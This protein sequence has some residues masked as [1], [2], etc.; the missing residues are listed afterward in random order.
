MPLIV[1]LMP[2]Y[3][4]PHEADIHVNGQ[5]VLITFIISVASGILFGIAPA[6]QL[7]RT[8]VSQ[9]MQSSSR[10]SSE[11]GRG[12]KVR[13]TLI[14]AEIA[15]TIILLAG[16]S[17]AI[18]SFLALERVPL[19][20]QPEH[21]LAMNIS[22]P[23]GSYTSWTARNSFFERLASEFRAIPGV[24]TATFTETAL[25]PYIG[26]NADFEIAGQPKTERQQLRIG[27]IG[28]AVFRNRRHS[29]CYRGDY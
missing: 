8:G 18:R 7:A 29:L 24:R 3:S 10:G 16:A 23:Q 19:G 2:Q 17:V 11:S 5:V 1:G 6:L 28:S 22:L 4:V 13:S 27:L 26:F 9:A 12:G 21:V 25:P 14:A 20:Y 15:L